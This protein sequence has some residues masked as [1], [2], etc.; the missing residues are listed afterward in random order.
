MFSLQQKAH[1]VERHLSHLELDGQNATVG[2]PGD[3]CQLSRCDVSMH[4]QFRL[5]QLCSFSTFWLCCSSEG[6]YW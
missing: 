6:G 1:R 4:L 3:Q 5:R 2:D